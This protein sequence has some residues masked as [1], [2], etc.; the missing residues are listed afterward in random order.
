MLKYFLSKLQNVFVKIVR[1][2]L[3]DRT[4]LFCVTSLVVVSPVLAPHLDEMY[5]SKLI[6]VSVNIY[7]CVCQNNNKMYLRKIGHNFFVSPHL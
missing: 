5:F 4:Q 6:N 1:Y 3:R 2:I 7:K